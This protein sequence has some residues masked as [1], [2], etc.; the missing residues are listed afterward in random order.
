MNSISTSSEHDV[1]LNGVS[2]KAVVESAVKG[3]GGADRLGQILAEQFK[4]TV[5]MDD[6]AKNQ[7][8]AHKKLV[9]QFSKF[10][11]GIIEDSEKLSMDAEFLDKKKM[12]ELQSEVMPLVVEWINSDA[13]FCRKLL[14]QVWKE[15][16]EVVREIAQELVFENAIEIEGGDD[17]LDR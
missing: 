13:I 16:P 4:G 8:M 10:F 3:V 14:S 1:M 6:I 5:D 12:A 15:N 7:R 17:G 2:L 9:L 11:T